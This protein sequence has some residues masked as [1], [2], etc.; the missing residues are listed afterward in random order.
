MGKKGDDV[1]NAWS[2]LMDVPDEGTQ[3]FQGHRE[4]SFFPSSRVAGQRFL[5]V[6]EDVV[7]ESLRTFI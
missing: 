3:Y 6:N 7:K 5:L 2:R 1:I 4:C